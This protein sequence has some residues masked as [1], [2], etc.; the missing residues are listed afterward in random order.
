MK[1]V[2]AILLGLLLAGTSF[3]KETYQSYL[4]KAKAYEAENKIVYALAA[5][6]DAMT[7]NPTVSAKEAYDSFVSLGEK[8]S[9]K[10][11]TEWQAVYS[12]FTDYFSKE[13]V[14]AIYLSRPESVKDDDE[15]FDI[16]V[17][18]EP[19][20]KFQRLFNYISKIPKDPPILFERYIQKY[21]LSLD[22]V[23]AYG[24]VLCT[25]PTVY[26][27][28]DQEQR[29]RFSIKNKEA[30]DAIKKMLAYAKVK[31]LVI[32]SQGTDIT[33]PSKAEIVIGGK[34]SSYEDSVSA[35]EGCLFIQQ[36]QSLF[37]PVFD[38]NTNTGLMMTSTEVT[39]KMYQ[40][41]MGKSASGKSADNKPVT[42]VSF[43][44]ALRF[45]NTLSLRDGRTPVY[46]LYGSKDISTWWDVESDY[47]DLSNISV[48]KNADGYRLPTQAEWI[49]AARGGFWGECF[50]Y[51]AGDTLSEVGWYK[52]NA[53]Q[54]G[55][56]TVFDVAQKKCNALGLYDMSGNAREWVEERL[57]L[58]GSVLLDE[59]YCNVV[60]VTSQKTY[61]KDTDLGFRIVRPAK[62][63]EL[64]EQKKQYEAFLAERKIRIQQI[65]SNLFV[66]VFTD[67][68]NAIMFAKTETTQELYELVVHE[69]PSPSKGKKRPIEK[70]SF[71]DAIIFCNKLSEMTNLTPAYSLNG[72]TDVSKWPSN[73]NNVT[74]DE[75]ANGFRLPTL[76]EWK[77]C[78]NEGLPYQ[79]Y[80]YSGSEDVDEVA[81][82]YGNSEDA[83][84][85]ERTAQDVA[86]KKPNELGIYDMSGN[87]AEWVWDIYEDS[88]RHLKR[89]I[90]GGDYYDSDPRLSW[91]AE[92]ATPDYVLEWG[93]F[94]ITRNANSQEIETAKKIDS[95]RKEKINSLIKNMFVPVVKE[96]GSGFMMAKTEMTRELWKLLVRVSPLPPQADAKIPQEVTFYDAVRLCNILSSLQGLTP[97]YSIDGITNVYQWEQEESYE[98]TEKIQVNPSADGYRLPTMKE[99]FYAAQGGYRKSPYLFSGSDKLD[100]VAWY[101]DNC[102]EYWMPVATKKPNELGLYDMSGNISEWVWDRASEKERYALGGDTLDSEYEMYV[103]EELAQKYSYYASYTFGLRF[104]RNAL[105][106][107]LRSE[108]VAMEKLNKKKETWVQSYVKGQSLS[109]T[110]QE[111][112]TITAFK[113]A[114][115]Q[116]LWYYVQ[117]GNPVTE[118]NV[119]GDNLPVLLDDMNLAAVFCNTLSQMQGLSPVYTLAKN[120]DG[121]TIITAIDKNANGWRLPTK[122]E[123]LA[124]SQRRSVKRTL[125][126]FAIDGISYDSIYLI[127]TDG[128]TVSAQEYLD[129][130]ES[131][132]DYEEYPWYD[133][134]YSTGFRIVRN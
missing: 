96:D 46:S 60:N 29:I 133:E 28:S 48:A 54:K 1:K 50:T 131:D 75:S 101:S 45:C 40:T 82:I 36:N 121:Y 74:L 38:E 8:L 62:E 93:G 128:E 26:F 67:E 5:Y 57:T 115:T 125:V 85:G 69:N 89:S 25:L 105:P 6:Y 15:H 43:I 41:V 7:A 66:T 107:E 83:K 14:A 44:D 126:E 98:N 3:A 27:F 80:E 104:V 79:L 39:E 123:L 65:L 59:S 52:D 47:I 33:I 100:S 117:G 61:S 53:S 86:T 99:W 132:D 118:Q 94:R 73:M 112:K 91:N 32:N 16:V 77:L 103:Q 71:N 113:T 72:T 114:I 4:T 49:Y 22:V 37:V 95:Q 17:K 10:D 21:E 23:N 127:N 110:M 124:I 90:V 122:E 20:Y 129:Y 35:V 24:S 68:E 76:A 106:S 84:T 70:I 56:R 12:E 63:S 42:E 55:T 51:S 111:G 30:Q 78:A 120:S 19:T 58:G 92:G 11:A 31:R 34:T 134:V 64:E 18:I 102:D 13:S 2:F 9:K 116:K 130:W 119:R 88:T 108:I 109:V 97:V 81:W 87:V